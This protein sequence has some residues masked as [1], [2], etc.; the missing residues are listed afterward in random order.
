M[1][2]LFGIDIAGTVAGAM[3]DGLLPVTL[4][5]V[6]AGQRDP[7]D[8]TSGPKNSIKKHNCRGFIQDYTTRQIDGDIV[9]MGDRKVLILGA[10]LPS[11]VVPEPDDQATC[12]GRTYT[13]KYVNRDP[14]AATYECQG[15]GL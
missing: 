6:S 12:E 14:A 3:A 13:I 8:L 15:R 2:D 1:P 7:A 5:K 4:L 9:K 11:G 10:T